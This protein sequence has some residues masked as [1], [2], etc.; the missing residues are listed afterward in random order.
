MSLKSLRQSGFTLIELMVVIV[1]AGLLFA[2]SSV[3]LGQVNTTA[4]SST[5]VNQILADLKS[6]QLLAMSGD[7]GDSGAAALHGIEFTSHNYTLFSGS[8]FSSID[9]SNYTAELNNVNIST[10]LP[11][12]QIIFNKGDGSV[13]NFDSSGNTITVVVNDSSRVISLNRFGALSLQ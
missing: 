4:S 3:N 11:N 5:T 13:A 12:N 7:T 6:Q 10:S 1:I 9:P 8:S 2:L